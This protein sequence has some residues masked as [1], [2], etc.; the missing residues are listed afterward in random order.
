MKR[1]DIKNEMTAKLNELGF[2]KGSWLWQPNMAQLTVVIS[3]NIKTFKLKSGISRRDFTYEM[4]RLAGLAEAY[5][6]EPVK[7]NGSRA[8]LNGHGAHATPTA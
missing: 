8:S 5:G 7:T 1:D 2:A 4:G 3:G 6:V